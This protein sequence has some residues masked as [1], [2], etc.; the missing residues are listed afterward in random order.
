MSHDRSTFSRCSRMTTRTIACASSLRTSRTTTSRPRRAVSMDLS[1]RRGRNLFVL[2]VE[3][4]GG[5]MAW[6]GCG[7]EL[8]G[9]RPRSGRPVP[10]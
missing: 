8:Q 6:E 4:R 7:E 9:T 1:S 10:S 2:A 3:E 5:G